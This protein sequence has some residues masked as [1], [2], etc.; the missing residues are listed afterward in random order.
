MEIRNFMEDMV[1]NVL[2]EL[3]EGKEDICKCEK[4]RLDIMAIALNNIKPKY[5]VTVKGR[6]YAKLSELEVQFRADVIRE[7]AKAF[8]MV[9]GKPQ[10]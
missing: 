5:V 2:D 3:L 4:C 8:N 7:L 1:K 6:V 10:H 9:K